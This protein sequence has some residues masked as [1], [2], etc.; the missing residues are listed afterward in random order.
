MIFDSTTQGLDPDGGFKKSTS[1]LVQEVI[2]NVLVDKCGYSHRD[3]VFFGMGQGGMTALNVAVAIKE[4]LGGVISI[5]GPL[6]SEAPASLKLKCKT[7]VLVCAGTNSQWVN[8]IAEEK[9]KQVFQTTQVSRYRRSGDT[10]PKDRDEML[11]VMQFFA[12]RLRQ[13]AP[14]GTVEV[15]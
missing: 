11:P 9:L 2:K 4:E 1:L 8:S 5:G 3:I 13:S 15:T 12:R 14:K 7:P 6:P 10:M